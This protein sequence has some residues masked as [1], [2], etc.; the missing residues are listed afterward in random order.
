MKRLL[1][2]LAAGLVSASVFWGCGTDAGFEA[3]VIIEQS[4]PSVSSSPDT[5]LGMIGPVQILVQKSGTDDTPVPNANIKIFGGGASVAPYFN[6]TD[7]GY[8]WKDYGAT[9]L[10]GD[11]FEWDTRTDDQGAV[12]VFLVG[13]TF[14][15]PGTDDIN[16]GMG[17]SAVISASA[18]SFDVP[19]T[20]KCS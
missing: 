10:A 3:V 6:G 2:I 17:I 15:C 14:L 18:N 5:D 20:I 1:G 9:Q 7:S 19:V 11:G 8:I 12:T 13:H 4:P 16:G